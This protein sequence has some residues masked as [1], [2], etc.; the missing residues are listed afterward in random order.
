MLIPKVISDMARDRSIAPMDVRVWVVAADYL[1]MVEFRPLKIDTLRNEFK[2]TVE[3]TD[4]AMK[5]PSKSQIFRS[6][7]RLVQRGYLERGQRD[8]SRGAINYR[9]PLSRVY[10]RD[11][12]KRAG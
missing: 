11:K 7:D 9:V 6:L 10:P 2:R 8:G 12:D 4:D 5:V 3:L 1:E